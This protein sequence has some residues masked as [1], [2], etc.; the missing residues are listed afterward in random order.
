MSQLQQMQ[1]SI[2]TIAIK[3]SYDR[4]YSD[5]W[6]QIPKDPSKRSI[7]QDDLSALWG[8]GLL[9]IIELNAN[10]P[11]GLAML[12]DGDQLA[13]GAYFEGTIALLNAQSNMIDRTVSLGNMPSKDGAR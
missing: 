10:G 13:V 11:R 8:V 7:L 1:A 9:H 12:P 4:P 5:I 2:P 6:L 3:K